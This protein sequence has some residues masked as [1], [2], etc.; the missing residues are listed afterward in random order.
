MQW[1]DCVSQLLRMYPFAFE[2]SSVCT[3]STVQ[4]FSFIGRLPMLEA[5]H[6]RDSFSSIIICILR[7]Y[8]G[9]FGGFLGLCSFLSLWELLMQ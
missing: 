1:V 4:T 8:S 2:F 7:G 6:D 3:S 9:F 5:F